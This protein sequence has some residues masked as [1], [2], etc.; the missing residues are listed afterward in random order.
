MEPWNTQEPDRA[1]LYDSL[2]GVLKALGNGHRLAL[3][4]FLAQG[5]HS[6]DALA[7]A[8]GLAVTTTSAHLQTLKRAGLVVTRRQGTTVFYRLSGDDVTDLFI[9]AKRL[10]L[11]HSP[12]L[13]EDLATFLA[14]AA[15]ES[16]VI[17]AGDVT[18]DM[19]VLDV[20]PSGDY[21][22]AHFPG[23]VSIPRIELEARIEEV[24]ADAPVVVYCRGEFC[25]V[26]RETAAWLVSQ[27]F[28]ARAMDEGV[29]EWR[30]S[31]TV[32]LASTEASEPDPNRLQE[33]HA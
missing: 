10:A 9:A 24:P 5:E 3:V 15:D 8:A 12:Q 33:S 29:M 18:P 22:A 17:A 11:S 25:R 26:A 6:V 27:G 23:A 14:T 7:K 21:A 4:E 31:G 2:A 13:R 30:A 1:S 16:I 28:D 32:S 20:R 19:T